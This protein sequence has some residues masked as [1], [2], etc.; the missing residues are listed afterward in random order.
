MLQIIELLNV[1]DL[2]LDSSVHLCDSVVLAACVLIV[3][4]LVLSHV[5][6]A[7]RSILG[8]QLISEFSIELVVADTEVLNRAGSVR[9]RDDLA[10]NRYLLLG[11]FSNC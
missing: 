5:A 6:S 1:V 7:H 3:V 8:N 4:A 9:D 10:N 11:D 2:G